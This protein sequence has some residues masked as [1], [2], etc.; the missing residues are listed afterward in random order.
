ML[1]EQNKVPNHFPDYGCIQLENLDFKILSS[2]L[3]S[4]VKSEKG[5]K[6][7]DIC[8]WIPFLSVFWEIQKMK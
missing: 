6:S 2:D 4:N 5:F 1:T 7:W 3:Q 8:F